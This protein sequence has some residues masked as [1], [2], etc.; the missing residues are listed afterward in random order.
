M[1]SRF[2]IHPRRPASTSRRQQPRPPFPHNTPDD[3]TPASDYH[4]SPP[5]PRRDDASSST[6]SP[7][8]SSLGSPPSMYPGPAFTYDFTAH[9]RPASPTPSVYSL[10]SSTIERSFKK[11]AGRFVNARS[12]VYGLPADDLEVKRLDN[13][14]YMFKS[15]WG[16]IYFGP[17]EEVLA[18]SDGPQKAIL[19]LGCGSG[20][21]A[22]EMATMFPHCTV[23][24]VDLAPIQ[25]S[26]IPPPNFR[27]EVDDVNLGLEHFEGQFDLVHSRFISTGIK[28]YFGLIDQIS[29]VLRP[30]GLLLLHET[31][32]RAYDSKHEIIEP[33]EYGHPRH[34]FLP[35]FLAKFRSAAHARR[36]N[37]DA[38]WLTEGWL[39]EH[40]AYVDVDTFDSWV[41][42]GQ[43]FPPE[44]QQENVVGGMMRNDLTAF[45]FSCR[46]VFEGY[47]APDELE[48]LE[49]NVLAEVEAA[50]I[51]MWMR[52]K[53]VWARRRS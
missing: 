17:V 31:D 47:G 14:H 10:T 23:V 30:G 34:A 50:R 29:R 21:W 49:R 24:G 38:A 8:H 2:S 16:S 6:S 44:C 26:Y 4:Y 7:F 3:D 53:S 37:L 35:H 13:Q 5:V 36:G 48:F 40:R 33:V 11:V 27:V 18:P 51:P 39:S 32:F 45:I 25:T 15:I 41:P 1:L 12:D 20:L 22:I 42:T 43:F 52:V 28:D 46:T 9:A 19:D